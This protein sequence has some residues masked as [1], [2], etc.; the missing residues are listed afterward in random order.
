M[1]DRLVNHRREGGRG[2]CGALLL[3]AGCGGGDADT[4]AP[5]NMHESY[6]DIDTYVACGELP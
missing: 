2:G 5:I 4:A 1:L 6:D 3:L